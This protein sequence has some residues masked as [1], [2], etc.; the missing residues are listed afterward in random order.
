MPIDSQKC[1]RTFNAAVAAM[2]SSVGGADNVQTIPLSDNVL[3]HRR[4]DGQR[5]RNPV[6]GK[7]GFKTS[8]FLS[9]KVAGRRIQIESDGEQ[10]MFTLAEVYPP[11]LAYR[12]QNDLV[13]I[14]DDE[15]VAWSV[16][17]CFAELNCGNFAWLEGKYAA[18]LI[19]PDEGPPDLEFGLDPETARRAAR[20]E[21]ALSAAG[22]SYVLINELWCR[23]PFTLQNVKFAFAVR[24][25]KLTTEEKDAIVRFVRGHD[26]VTIGDCANELFAALD[27]P[28]E[29]VFAAVAQGLVE[30]DFDEPFSLANALMMPR[31]AFWLRR[32]D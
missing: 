18:E 27:C 29:K 9:S 8:S 5:W 19:Y 13:E 23:H 16:T 17:D 12:E 21:R 28:T 6:N 10:G 3:I 7:R 32:D 11:I 26:E 25:I 20:L 14:Q 1:L 15:G 4:R 22:Y 31:K 24:D 30:I 2:I